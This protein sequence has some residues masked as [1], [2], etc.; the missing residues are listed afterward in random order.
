MILFVF[1]GGKAE[2]MVFDSIGR[3]FLS[4]EELCIV[5]CRHDLPT[6]Y[7][8]LRAN[9]Y[10]LLRSLPFEENGI[11]LPKDQRRDTLFSQTFLF[12]DYDF[13]NRLGTQRV[14]D[15]LDDMLDFFD[16]ETGNGKLYVNYP[17][18]ESLKYTKQLPDCNYWKYIATREEC[19]SH[20]FKGNAERFAY[21]EAKSYKFIDLARTHQETVIENWRKLEEQNVR[22]ANYLVSGRNEM[23]SDKQ[24]ICQKRVFEAQKRVFVDVNESVAILNS[25]PIFLFDYLK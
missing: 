14:N 18:I 6:L 23:P 24:L 3:L 4:G 16:D 8:S 7:A 2:P 11:I 21:A 25:F 15:I 10:D 19:V 5:K 12:F 13:Q 9:D 22:K 17:M 20:Q 1:E